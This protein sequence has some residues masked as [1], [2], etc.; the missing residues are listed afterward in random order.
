MGGRWGIGGSGRFFPPPPSW[1]QVPTTTT[2]KTVAYLLR[3]CRRRRGEDG[4][5][6]S[7]R[8]SN[9]TAEGPPA[10]RGGTWWATAVGLLVARG[11]EGD[12]PVHHGHVRQYVHRCGPGCNHDRFGLGRHHE[13]VRLALLLGGGGLLCSCLPNN[14][15]YVG[16]RI[17]SPFLQPK[18]IF[19]ACQ[20]FLSKHGKNLLQGS[21]ISIV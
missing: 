8:L 7:S 1:R 13:G 9:T 4:E 16:I 11:L 20:R 10:C 5:L 6:R 19:A 2:T 17:I 18:K 3:R 14:I 21:K 12:R 15:D